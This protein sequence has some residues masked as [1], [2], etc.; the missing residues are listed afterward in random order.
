MYL[1]DDSDVPELRAKYFILFGQQTSA[2]TRVA[3]AAADAGRFAWF[4]GTRPWEERPQMNAAR[5]NRPA[6]T[7]TLD[8]AAR[9]LNL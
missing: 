8:T 5:L 7:L 4:D 6:Y 1:L 2:S 3:R 9:S